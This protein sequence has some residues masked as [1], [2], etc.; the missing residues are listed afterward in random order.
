MVL[1]MA[2]SACR[3]NGSA[4]I[5]TPVA[6]TIHAAEA[7]FSRGGKGGLHTCPELPGQVHAFIK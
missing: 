4:E 6:R 1:L 5:R 3:M 2:P 7:F